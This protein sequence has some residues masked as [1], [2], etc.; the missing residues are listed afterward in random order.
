[1]ATT[2]SHK[3][4]H[5]HAADERN[6]VKQTNSRRVDRRQQTKK[7]TRE[8]VALNPATFA[9]HELENFVGGVLESTTAYAYCIQLDWRKTSGLAR[10]CR[11]KTETL[12]CADSWS[13]VVVG[14]GLDA[15]AQSPKCCPYAPKC[16]KK[17]N[18]MMKRIPT[19]T[20]Y[21]HS[22]KQ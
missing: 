18:L 13:G 21:F 8:V 16:K 6:P 5:K 22:G 4:A 15:G 3:L 11:K 20:P 2:H 9:R 12:A 14:C 1:V 7:Q 10:H 19:F 17:L